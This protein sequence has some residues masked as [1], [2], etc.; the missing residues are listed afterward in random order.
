[1]VV[2]VNHD[3][4]QNQSSDAV[5]TEIATRESLCQFNWQDGDKQRASGKK[6]SRPIPRI[7]SNFT[8]LVTH[9]AQ[10]CP[11]NLSEI[12]DARAEPEHITRSRHV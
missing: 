9:P 12:K 3:C 11:T 4:T 7:I 10:W 8:C 1:N 2:H 5:C 6:T